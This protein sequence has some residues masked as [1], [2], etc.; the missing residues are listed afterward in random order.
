MVTCSLD[1]LKKC[2]ENKEIGIEKEIIEV[3]RQASNRR[4]KAGK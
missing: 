3:S 4:K 2:S 1:I